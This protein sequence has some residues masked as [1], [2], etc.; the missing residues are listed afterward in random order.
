M[1]RSV[2]AL[3]HDFD[4][5]VHD[6]KKDQALVGYLIDCVRELGKRRFIIRISLSALPDEDHKERVRDSIRTFRDSLA[7]LEFGEI[8]GMFRRSLLLSVIGLGF[9]V[10]AVLANRNLGTFEPV[11]AE[12]FAE[13]LTLV[14]W[15]SMWE[16][17]AVLLLEWQPHRRMI[18]IYRRIMAGPVIFRGIGNEKRIRLA[19]N[20]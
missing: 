2:E 1:L 8:R 14:A 12:V 17:I 7:E 9:P 3:H 4:G 10:P 13:G 6:L 16:A 19:R 5:T 15:V 11:M 20:P 18:R